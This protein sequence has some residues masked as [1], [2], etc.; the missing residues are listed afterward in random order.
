MTE[1][2]STY[3]FVPLNEKVYTPDWA[4]KVSQD[5]PFSD[6]EDGVIE[7]IYHNVSPL[8]IRNGYSDRYNP[9][10]YSAHVTVDSKK[11]YFIP[12]SSFKGMIR[13]TMEIMSFASLSAG[14]YTNRFF[15]KRDFGG[16]NNSGSTAYVQLMQKS[17]PAWLRKNGESLFLTP[18]DGNLERIADEDIVQL[19]PSFGR[20]KT[21]WKRNEAI[22]KDCGEWYPKINQNGQ[23]YRIVCTGAIQKKTKEFLFPVSRLDKVE[24][25]DSKVKTAFLTVHEP[26]PDFEQIRSFLDDGH[27]LAVFY[28]PGK[29]EY[30]VKAVGLSSM[31]RYPY[32]ESVQDIVTRQQTSDSSKPDLP[33][34]IF[35]YISPDG[36]KSLR[37]RVQIGNAFTDRT[38]A[39]SELCPEVVGVLGQPK[40]SFY[41]FYL[42]QTSSPYKTYDNADGIAG[43]KMYRVHMGSSVTRLPQGNGGENV[44]TRFHPL[45][46]GL[47]FHVRIA[48]HNLRKIETGALLSALTLNKTKGAWHNL[49]LARGFGYGKLAIDEVKLNGF[50]FDVDEYLR[51]FE[52]EMSVFAQSQLASKTMF[53]NNIQITTLMGILSEH[54]DKDLQVMDLDGYKNAKNNNNFT[55][56]REKG[57]QVKSFMATKDIED[58]K[59]T[60]FKKEYASWYKEADTLAEESRYHEA[61]DK[62]QAIKNERLRKG[63][64]C[65][66]VDGDIQKMEDLEAQEVASQIQKQ[67]EEQEANRLKKLAAGL[68]ASLD[69][70]YGEESPKAGQYKVI[71]FK[72]LNNKVGQWMKKAK[73]QEL[74]DQ[75]KADYSSTFKRLLQPRCHPKKEDKE[76]N[77]PDSNLWRKATTFLGSSFEELLGDVFPG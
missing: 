6:G 68:A 22:Q 44:L 51:A 4:D 36:G 18:C 77:K 74:S 12:G 71:D 72:A 8:F 76:L 58:I 42:R 9:D 39:D 57:V 56:L 45:P 5:V 75:E 16:K 19:Y 62:Y 35:G 53:R 24:I 49:G 41:P 10:S 23:T 31:F 21:G 67:A 32:K 48:V 25:T 65:S 28:I 50:Q 70:T 7:L 46:C 60:A 64:D 47:H 61:R 17:R 55:T 34:T 30:D 11:L 69:E 33:E 27:E 14:Q 20:Y 38:V 43:R 52:K 29:D 3:N 66:E 15:G 59:D 13:S 26:S 2:T 54:D 40:A 63:L 37:G 73:E 1:I